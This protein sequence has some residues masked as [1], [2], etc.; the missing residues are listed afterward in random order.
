MHAR[1]MTHLILLYAGEELLFGESQ[2]VMP[3]LIDTIM[4]GCGG[5]VYA[6]A[7][8]SHRIIIQHDKRYVATLSMT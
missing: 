1:A 2:R 4:C 3:G 6:V 8:T 5:N 7:V